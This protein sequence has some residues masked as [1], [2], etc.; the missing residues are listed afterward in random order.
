MIRPAGSAPRA[1]APCPRR[2]RRPAR[3]K[4]RLPAPCRLPTPRHS[5]WP[6][7]K[8]NSARARPPRAQRR[9]RVRE[10]A[11]LRPPR[12]EVPAGEARGHEQDHRQCGQRPRL[13]PAPGLH[14]HTGSGRGGP[15][16]AAPVR[17]AGSHAPAPPAP[18][19]PLA[20]VVRRRAAPAASPPGTGRSPRRTAPPGTMGARPTRA[21]PRARPAGE[22]RPPGR[23]R[24][25]EPRARPGP[26]VGAPALPEGLE[27]VDEIRGAK[28]HVRDGI[29]HGRPVRSPTA[30][31]GQ[32]L[33][34]GKRPHP[35]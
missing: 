20:R 12:P 16:S 25:S 24:P 9:G 17:P 5:P 30:F 28:S 29:D 21:R 14:P 7:Q 23:V 8:R 11:G 18:P 19:G 35:A 27:A 4:P 6:P 10:R 13:E 26:L 3:R 33:H 32:M 22:P 1:C 15:R 2:R 34:G 31:R